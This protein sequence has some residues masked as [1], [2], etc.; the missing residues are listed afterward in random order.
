MLKTARKFLM[1]LLCLLIAVPVS[2][3]QP[4]LVMEKQKT[5]INEPEISQAFY[6]ELD[7]EPDYYL[8]DED[9]EFDLY[10]GLLVPDLP[11]IST[12]INA[13]VFKKTT[14]GKEELLFLLEGEKENW[15]EFFEPFA[16][17]LYYKGPEKEKT[18]PAGQYRIRISG[19][20]NRGKYVLAVGREER[21]TFSETVAMVTV[22]PT[23]KRD[24]FEKSPLSAFYN[25]VGLFM[26]ISLLIML[27]LA[28]GVFWLVKYIRKQ[29]HT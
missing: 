3:H 15:E 18:V 22:L 9:R 2:A 17:D 1:I 11:G 16:G 26:L 13:A 25:L 7:G 5:E 8:L 20:D 24:F 14:T 27:A 4:R 10:V 23:L 19:S 12:G 21:F 29:K 6:A 28:A